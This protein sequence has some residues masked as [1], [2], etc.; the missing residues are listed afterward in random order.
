M[1]PI[2]AVP[3]PVKTPTRLGPRP[4]RGA[5]RKMAVILVITAPVDE[6]AVILDAFRTPK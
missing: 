3:C 1:T 2:A 5:N 6:M 4:A